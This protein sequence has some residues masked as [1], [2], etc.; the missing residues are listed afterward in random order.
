MATKIVTKNSSTASAVP[1]ASD[2]VQGELAVNVADKRLFTEDNGGSIVELG[3]NPSTIDINAGTIDGAVVGGTTPAAIT[4]STVTSTGNI[5]VAGTVDGRDVAT[6]GTKLDGVEAGAD[7]TD[8]TNVTAAGALMDSEVTNLAQ[9]KA[10]DSADYA[11]AAQGTTADAA[12]P[13]AG[14]ALTGAVTTNSTFDGRDVATDGTKL[15][16]IEV[17][18]DVTDTTNVVASLTAGSNITIA[19]DGTIASTASG[20]NETLAQTLALG[21]VTGGTDISVSSGDNIVMAANSTVDGRDLSVD[22]AKL[23]LINQG[24]ATTDSPTFAALTSTGEITANGGIALGDN[25][26][27]TFGASD[28]LQIFHNGTESFIREVGEGG[29]KIDTNGPDLTLRVNATETAL[30][31]TSNGAVTAY[32]DNAAKLA[33]TSTGIDVTGTA[34]MDGLTVDG[35]IA[36][37]P[38]V[39]ISNNGGTWVAG[40]ETGRLQFYITDI[41]GAGAREVASIRSTT[42]QGG[43]TTDGTL[44][45]WTSP[46]DTVAKKSMEIDGRTG[47]ISFY[48]DTGTTPKFFWDASA[49][50]LGIG[51]SSPTKDLHISKGGQNGVR[52]TSTT[53]GADF[54]LLSSVSGQNGFGIYDYNASGYRFNIDSSG[55]VGIGTTAPSQALTVNGTDARIYLTG[56][57]TDIDMDNSHSGQL[58][59][60]GNAYGFGIALNASGAQLYTNSASRDL[61]FGVN[62]TEVMRVTNDSVGIGTA[63]PDEQLDVAGNIGF[64]GRFL[65][66][67]GSSAT[68]ASAPKICVGY[69]YDTGFFQNTTNTIGFATAGSERMRVDSSGRLGINITNPTEKLHVIGNARITGA[70]SSTTGFGANVF[71]QS[72]GKLFRSTS[73]ARY[74]NSIEDVTHGLAELLTLRPVTYKGNEDGDTVFS[75]LIAEEVHDAGLTEFVQYNEEGQPDAL[76]YGNMVSICIKAIQEQQTLIESL[77]ARIAALEE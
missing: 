18:A 9:V 42:N 52:L 2:L 43:T 22:G 33:T 47:D 70:Y 69:D 20:G 34:T 49:E 14:G 25:D 12:L 11:T 1:T 48:E 50:S 73:S 39:R 13:K 65:P 45:F 71:V 26:K 38:I 51:T 17:S 19:A 60:D 68:S 8:T 28:D 77:T 3:T 32:Y 7:V 5:V 41:S 40:N 16:G 27:A 24:V 66:T 10:F 62:E 61:I 21:A 75:G 6:D 55:N 46:Y 59:L 4:G 37:P 76:A 58:S 74:K 29:L 63:S 57:N 72:T 54:G 30:V 53:F 56:A 64:S 36:S 67:S 23:D 31:A 44:E 35:T 15:D